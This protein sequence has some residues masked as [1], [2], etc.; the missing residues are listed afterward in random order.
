MD[1]LKIVSVSCENDEGEWQVKLTD[2]NSEGTFWIC[3]Y[4]QKKSDFYSGIVKDSSNPGLVDKIIVV[5]AEQQDS[6]I[7][8]WGKGD[9]IKW[10]NSISC[11]KQI[12]LEE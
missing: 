3:A 5:Q 11:D 2:L 6:Q 12:I 4:L 1:T 10:L 7:D 9:K 8:T